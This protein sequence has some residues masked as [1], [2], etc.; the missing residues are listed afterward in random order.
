[1][2]KSLRNLSR[3]VGRD[4]LVVLTSASVSEGRG[5]ESRYRLNRAGR[6]PERPGRLADINLCVSQNETPTFIIK[7]KVDAGL[8]YN[9]MPG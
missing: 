4:S 7:T 9:V 5:F 2:L 1:M 8:Q 6:S 3:K